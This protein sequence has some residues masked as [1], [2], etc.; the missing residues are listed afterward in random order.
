MTSKCC[1]ST[2]SGFWKL[3]ELGP[4]LEEQVCKL[5]ELGNGPTVDREERL[6]TRLVEREPAT[7]LS[8]QWLEKPKTSFVCGE[9]DHGFWRPGPLNMRSAAGRWIEAGIGQRIRQPCDPQL[10]AAQPRRTFSDLVR[11]R[12]VDVIR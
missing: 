3:A 10:N 6:T 11:Q 12:R 2:A 7:D 1:P 8:N 9:Q 5:H 4:L